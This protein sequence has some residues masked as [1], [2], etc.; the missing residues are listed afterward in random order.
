[1]F[2]MEKFFQFNNQGHIRP[3]WNTT[4]MLVRGPLTDR[5]IAK[6]AKLG[7]YSAEYREKRRAKM[8]KRPHKNFRE[9]EGRL[10]YSPV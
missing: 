9:V 4:R 3:S 2:H 8:D 5:K 6:Y 7:W 10:I 1:M